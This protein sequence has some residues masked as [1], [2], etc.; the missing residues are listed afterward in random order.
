M[1]EEKGDVFVCV[2]EREDLL[3]RGISRVLF[4]ECMWG[5]TAMSVCV[6]LRV[7]VSVLAMAVYT[8]IFVR[9]TLRV[10]VWNRVCNTE[11]ARMCVPFV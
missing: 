11:L 9:E 7:C 4:F 2:R 5:C 6:Q 10:W 1:E 8:G 3:N